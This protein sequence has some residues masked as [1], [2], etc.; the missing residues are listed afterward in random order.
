MRYVFACFVALAGLMWINA[1]TANAYDAPRGLRWGM[2]YDSVCIDIRKLPREKQYIPEKPKADDE[3]PMGFTLSK[4]K[5][6][7]VLD[8]KTR[9]AYLVF[10]ST[11]GL[12]AFIHVLA[13]DNVKDT[14]NTVESIGTGRSQ[15]WEYYQKLTRGLKAKYGEPTVDQ[16]SGTYGE[17]I[18]S[19]VKLETNWVD[20][21]TG[22][23]I[24]A[25]I[26]R[27]KTNAVI[28]RRKTNAVIAR[29]DQYIVALVYATPAYINAKEEEIVERDEL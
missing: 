26:S 8:E 29:V 3:F 6:V 18:A 28:S 2:P 20:T 19:G 21:T 16:T 15:C 1:S 4:I 22:D 12:C 23:K 9:E 14:G 7:K 27:R 17:P 5:D 24:M 11:G 25:V 10:D 13:W